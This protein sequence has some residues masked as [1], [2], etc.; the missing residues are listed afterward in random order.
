MYEEFYGFREAPFSLTHDPRFYYQTTS[1]KNPFE[2]LRYGI[3]RGEGFIVICGETGTGKTTLCRTVIESVPQNIYT[4]MLTNPFL[5]EVDLLRAILQDF[6]V[7]SVDAPQGNRRIT[8]NDLIAALNTFL[9][10]LM[11]LNAHAVIVIDEAQ[12]IPVATLEQIRV[13]S[14]LETTKQ[15]LLQIVLVGQPKLKEVLE[16]PA[17]RQLNQRIS[18]RCELLPYTLEETAAYIQHRLSIV[19]EDPSRRIFS[20]EA[21]QCIHEHS[22][23]IPQLINRIGEA[24]LN[25]GASA[26]KK[27]IDNKTA[28]RAIRQLDLPKRKRQKYSKLAL[29][30]R[31]AIVVLV[32]A[33][34][35]MLWAVPHVEQVL[36]HRWLG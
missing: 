17:L 7:L 25:A 32:A 21:V 36:I 14:N 15:K 12:N 18:I 9:L 30:V 1:E 4:A 6:G 3:E 34:L 24:C 28:M 22:G 8:K 20:P 13:L 5:A 19:A 23:G 11:N 33:F 35:L 31:I 26:Q 10:S 16:R 2:L 29:A 27:I